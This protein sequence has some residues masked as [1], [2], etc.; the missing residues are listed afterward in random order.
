MEI[1]GGQQFL[2]PSGGVQTILDPA[3]GH[4]N[5]MHLAKLLAPPPQLLDGPLFSVLLY[6]LLVGGVGKLTE[7]KYM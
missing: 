1:G 6:H 7:T 2:D 3:W 4:Q 5:F